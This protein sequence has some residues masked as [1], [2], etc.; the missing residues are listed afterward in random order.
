M[1]IT[2]ELE[3]QPD[4]VPLATE[5][6][7]TLRLLTDHVKVETHGSAAVPTARPATSSATA[8]SSTPGPQQPASATSLPN[9]ALPQPPAPIQANPHAPTQPQAPPPAPAQVQAAAAPAPAQAAVAAAPA[10]SQ[11]APPAPLAPQPASAG[12]PPPRPLPQPY[13]SQLQAFLALVPR[14]GN[15]ATQEQA[16]VDII[17]V[18]R[19]VDESYVDKVFE[20]LVAAYEQCVFENPEVIPNGVMPYVMLY[21][22]VPDGLRVKMREKLVS[23][24]ISTLNRKRPVNVDRS[25]FFGYAD[26]FACLVKFEAVPM[27]GAIQTL[28]RLL[29]KTDSR[30]QAVT[31]LGKTVEYCGDQVVRVPESSLALL[32]RAL[33][34]VTEDTFQYD[35]HYILNTLHATMAAQSAAGAPGANA[36]AAL[37]PGQLPAGVAPL[38]TAAAAAAP[39]AAGVPAQTTPTGLTQIGIYHGHTATVFSMYYDAVHGQLFSAAQDGQL[40]C[41]GPEGVPVGRMDISSHYVCSVSVLPRSGT[42]VAAAVPNVEE[43]RPVDGSCLLGFA[44]PSTVPRV[45]AWSPRGKLQAPNRGIISFA[46]PLGDGDVFVMGEDTA[47]SDP[48]APVRDVVYV[49]DAARGASLDRLTPLRSYAEH[50]EMVTTAAAWAQNPNVFATAG[51][52]HTVLVWD[53]RLEGS[54]GMFGELNPMKGRA[55]AHSDMVS[56]L[57]TTENFLLSSCVDSFMCIWDFR[58]LS[59]TH[60][61]AVGPVVR[62]QIDETPILKMAVTGAPHSRLAALS[63]YRGLHVIDITNMTAPLTVSIQP[64]MDSKYQF[65]DLRWAGGQPVFFAASESSEIVV[66]GVMF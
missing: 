61:S 7:S 66:A 12:P 62:M 44:P 14:L 38:A 29:M 21:T 55:E 23:K 26:A 49:Y 46:V 35:M 3:I 16:V 6:I 53:R 40:L 9:G 39:T 64:P 27:D 10:R 24:V 60:G 33:G 20:E 32:W 51:R 42:V 8:A 65:H 28:S 50:T 5:L 45:G 30:C 59:M 31:M 17:A 34:T 1:K 37:P 58:Q 22:R 41:W 56:A 57:D 11:P 43:G 2:I 52:D 54:V 25:T 13:Q 36:P 18:L 63:T 47:A 4:E 19:S 15:A 48:N